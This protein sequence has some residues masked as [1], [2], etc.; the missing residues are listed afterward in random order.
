[1]WQFKHS[2]STLK[3]LLL[4]YG[5]IQKRFW[6]EEKTDYYNYTCFFCFEVTWIKKPSA[7]TG[8]STGNLRQHLQKKHFIGLHNMLNNVLQLSQEPGSVFNRGSNFAE[9]A[10]AKKLINRAVSEHLIVGNLSF[11]NS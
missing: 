2:V 6:K 10:V 9:K 8:W 7:S 3:P 11:Y 1:M 5:E 4:P